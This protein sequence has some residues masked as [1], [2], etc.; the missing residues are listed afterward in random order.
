MQRLSCSHSQLPPPAKPVLHE[1]SAHDVMH[2]SPF[3]PQAP[4]A[5]PVTHVVPLQHPPLQMFVV[6]LHEVEHAWVDVLHAWLAGHAA[7]VAHPQAPAKHPCDAPHAPQSP[8]LAP[9]AVS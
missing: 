9:H 2:A 3:A 8:P 5:I 4:V 1:P 7:L 6:P